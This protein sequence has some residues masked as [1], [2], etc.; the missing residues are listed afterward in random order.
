MRHV[1]RPKNHFDS[2]RYAVEGIVHVFRTQRHMRF[3]F[4]TVVVILLIGLLLNLGPIK[5]ALLFI[6]VSTVLMA[7]M[8]N[9]AVESV[10]DMI[11]QAYHPLAKLAKDI[12]AGAVLIASISAAI[13]GAILVFGDNKISRLRL[14]IDH[15]PQ[16]FV[17]MMSI[18]VLILIIVLISKV[19][20]GK[21]SILSGGI[22]SGHAA[23]SFFLASMLIY[24]A[25]DVFTAVLALL[26]AFLVAQ[27]RVEGKIHTMQ[28]VVIGGLLGFLFTT[29]AYSLH[30]FPSP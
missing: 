25:R 2:F 10:V 7:E 18:V 29:G 16:P 19:L 17:V 21:G 4:F 27:S 22:V 8:F 20:G 23:V 15:D 9:T 14:K 26:L 6:V 1:P 30:F 24:R 28:E 3:H 5:I 11:T 12:A 13:V